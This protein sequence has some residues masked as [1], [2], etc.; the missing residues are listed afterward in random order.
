MAAHEALNEAASNAPAHA[1]EELQENGW[2]AWPVIP[3][4]YSGFSFITFFQYD[5]SSLMDGVDTEHNIHDNLSDVWAS[6][7]EIVMVEALDDGFVLGNPMARSTFF[8]A[9]VLFK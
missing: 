7:E 2:R 4:P 9:G 1:Q 6:D 3:P 5:G 8:R